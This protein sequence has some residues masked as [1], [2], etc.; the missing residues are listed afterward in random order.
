MKSP[1][2]STL[3][4]LFLSGCTSSN[5]EAPASSAD[6]SGEDAQVEAL[7]ATVAETRLFCQ[8][9]GAGP[10]V[11]LLHGAQLDHRMWDETFAA[12][13]PSHRVV[14]YDTRGFGRSPAPRGPYRECDDLATLLDELGIERASLVGLARGGRIALEFAL[15]YPERAS[16]LVLV[17]PS[18]AG[19]PWS[20]RMQ[21]DLR[22]VSTAIHQR[23]SEMAAKLW[24]QTPQMKEAAAMP[25]LAERLTTIALENARAWLREETEEPLDPPAIER[26]T[27]VRAPTLVVT[28]TRDAKDF[29]EIAQ[30]LLAEL[31]NARPKLFDGAGHLV[32]MERP[33]TFAEA[34]EEFLDAR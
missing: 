22:F 2:S 30:K 29:Q 14:R 9:A 28:G 23:D 34:V 33:T 11:V 7:D 1:T 19:W 21:Q 26:L 3:L 8:V 6:E 27:S 13:A 24:L 25:H 5:A 31:P 32:P 18:L 17:A 10:A 16:A 20:Q 12:L 15:E 4:V